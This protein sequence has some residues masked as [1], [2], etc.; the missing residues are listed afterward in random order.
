MLRV[1]FDVAYQR[2]DIGTKKKSVGMAKLDIQG[3]TKMEW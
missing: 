2:Q 3:Q 1:T